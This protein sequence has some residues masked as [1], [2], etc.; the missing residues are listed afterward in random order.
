M[1]VNFCMADMLM[2]DDL[3]LDGHNG[4]AKAEISLELSRQLS[5]TTKY[6]IFYKTVD[7]FLRDFD[8][9]KTL[10]VYMA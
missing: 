5:K 1:S 4:S 6:Y 7:H 9:K 10:P 8:L 3:D 2:L